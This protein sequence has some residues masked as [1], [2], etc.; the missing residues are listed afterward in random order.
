MPVIRH[1]EELSSR[2]GA[3]WRELVCCDRDTFGAP[4]P[5]RALRYLIDAGATGPEVD[6]DAGEAMLYVAA[7]SGTLSIHGDDGSPQPLSTESVA[8]LPA[9]ARLRLT[10]GGEGMDALLALTPAETGA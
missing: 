7:G 4:V 2:E 9:G 1:R 10:A 5:L 6:L 8:W 3:G